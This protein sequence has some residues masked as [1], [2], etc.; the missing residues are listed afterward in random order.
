MVH[1]N[2]KKLGFTVIEVIIASMVL[3]LTMGAAYK[4][5]SST[6]MGFQRSTKVLA[7]QNEMRNGLT[8]IREEMQRASYRSEIKVNGSE[9]DEDGYEFHLCNETDIDGST[10]KILA[11]WTICKPFKKD[12]TGAVYECTLRISDRKI[13]YTKT[14]KE[15]KG[16]SDPSETLYNDKVV[17]TQVGKIKFSTEEFTTG[18][19][20][21]GV[22]V[23]IE[24][25]AF[26]STKGQPDLNVYAQTGAKIEVKLVKGF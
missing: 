22:Q 6:S 23:N 8:F 1:K 16:S 14:E 21:K 24:T 15:T 17:M 11:K 10:N 19:S 25:F 5:F 2:N 20:N 7:M 26:N 3:A 12:N 18:T 9:I 13:L 4:I